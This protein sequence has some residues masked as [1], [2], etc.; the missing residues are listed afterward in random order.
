MGALALGP[1]TVATVAGGTTAGIETAVAETG[2]AAAA[3][4][5]ADCP[6][7]IQT[8]INTVYRYV[9]DGVT[10]YY[11]ITNDLVRRTGEQYQALGGKIEPILG[12][13][14]LSRFDA[15]AVEQVLIEQAGLPNLLNKINSIAQSNPIYPEAIRRGGEILESIGFF[16]R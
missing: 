7:K 8:G 6:G 10:K 11:G 5:A 15:R 3:C 9:V 13:E 14:N 12:L 2:T 4:A 16:G 1:A